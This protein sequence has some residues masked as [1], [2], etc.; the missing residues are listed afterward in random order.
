MVYFVRSNQQMLF[1]ANQGKFFFLVNSFKSH[2]ISLDI[3]CYVKEKE[4]G[5]GTEFL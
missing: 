2:D 4:N 3:S 5:N 1:Q